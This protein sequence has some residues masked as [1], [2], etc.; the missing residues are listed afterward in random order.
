MTISRRTL[1]MSAGALCVFAHSSRQSALANDNTEYFYDELGRLIRVELSDGTIVVYA[2][3][4]VGNRTRVIHGDDVPFNTT[5]QVTGTGPVNLRTLADQAGYTGVTN[6]TITFQVGSAVTIAA[7]SGGIGIDT[8]TWPSATKSISLTLQVSGKVYGGGGQ[9]GSPSTT[10]GSP[11]G[12]G[13]DAVYCREN[14][15][16][17]VN[18]GGQIKGGGGG[19]GWGGGWR[20]DTQDAEGQPLTIYRFGGGG[21]GGFPNGAGGVSGGPGASGVGGTTSGGGA[22]GAGGA[23][24]GSGRTNGAGGAGGGSGASGTSGAAAVGTESCNLQGTTCH[25]KMPSGGGG[26]AGYAVRKNG[27]TVTV[28]NNGTIT[29]TVG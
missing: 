27:K 19:G 12:A 16:V 21:G 5:I 10:A 9:G 2:Y 8:G 15:A 7:L 13:G 23:G 26:A 29:G 25:Y 20:T 3:D 28:T 11:A 4:A 22:G 1:L 18:P 24:P 17:T 6:A 14:I